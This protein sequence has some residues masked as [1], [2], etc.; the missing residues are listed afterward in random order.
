MLGAA[1]SRE[2][3]GQASN[4]CTKDILKPRLHKVFFIGEIKYGEQKVKV[5]IKEP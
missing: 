1:L 5:E 4:G 2:K 3:L